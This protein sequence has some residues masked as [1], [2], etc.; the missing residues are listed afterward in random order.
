M[1]DEMN[2]ALPPLIEAMRRV[3]FACD[4]LDEKLREKERLRAEERLAQERRDAELK[5]EEQVRIARICKILALKMEIESIREQDDYQIA[6][7][8]IE[9]SAWWLTHRHGPVLA[10]AHCNHLK[11]SNGDRWIAFGS[12]VFLVSVAIKGCLATL[13]TWL[14]QKMSRETVSIAQ[15]RASLRHAVSGSV[16]HLNGRPYDYYPIR[17]GY[18][19]FGSTGIRVEGFV[20]HFLSKVSICGQFPFAD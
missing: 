11:G 14:N 2:A 19:T 7:S 10:P 12:N 17:D 15:L 6:R 13:E 8:L 4:A 16:S 1:I 3:Q 9:S 5:A 18:L 20:D